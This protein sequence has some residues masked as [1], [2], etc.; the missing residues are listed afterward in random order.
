[1][2]VG[3]IGSGPA[4]EAIRATLAGADADARSIAPD[5]IGMVDTAVVV[6][7]AGVA[8]FGDANDAAIEEG[9]GWIAVELGGI[10]GRRIESVDVAVSTLASGGP[11]FECLRA[12]VDANVVDGTVP[13]ANT[14]SADAAS[15]RIAGAL[16]GRRV[17]CLLDGGADAGKVTELPYAE[18]RLFPIP[19]CECGDSEADGVEIG[20]RIERRHVDR[21][22]DETIERV[23]RA[24]DER[25]G[26]VREIG[27]AASIPGPYYLARLCDT[28]GFSDVQTAPQ[29]AGVAADWNE[30]FVKAFGET[31][32]RYCAGVCRT[33]DFDERPATALDG[34]VAPSTF[35]LPSEAVGPDEPIRWIAG[36]ALATGDPTHLPVEFVVFPPPNERHRP[37][38]TTGLGLGNSPVG[39]LLSGL[40]E[41]LER[42]ATMLAWYSTFEPLGLAVESQRFETLRRRARAEK[43][44]VTATLVTQDVNVPV[45]AVAVHR[46]TEWPRFAVGSGADLDATAAA[47]A[48][49]AE[50]LQNWTNC[51]T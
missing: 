19:G 34:A 24:I 15:A 31:L 3:I 6:G 20:N 51:V 36:E 9:P 25:V 33:L 21:S 22:L 7:R 44:T 47:E 39:A 28:A 23:E 49:L 43:L 50:A 13:A 8:R 48:A 35:V 41:V 12:R 11:C 16:A 38:I 10:G 2:T 14:P 32:E 4:A 40:Y 17:L 5:G 26:I 18:R 45:V 37:S 27:E 30:A 46:E 29:A 42:D 1:M